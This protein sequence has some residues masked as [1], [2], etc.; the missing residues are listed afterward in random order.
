MRCLPRLIPQTLRRSPAVAE[1]R[2]LPASSLQG[3]V[4][5]QSWLRLP[6]PHNTA[7]VEGL[8]HL[9]SPLLIEFAS[10]KTASHVLDVALTSSTVEPR[11]RRR[12]IQCLIACGLHTLAAD[13]IGSRVCD[14]CW[15][16]ADTFLKGK[17]AAALVPYLR[18]LHGSEYGR[19]FARKLQLPVF[20][21][22]RDVWASKIAQ[23]EA[24]KKSRQQQAAAVTS[25]PKLGKAATLPAGAT[26]ADEIDA[27]FAA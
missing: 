18:E 24:A 4:L 22:S 10:D 17:M 5:L 25:K 16:A 2:T 3:A 26:E 21:T 23:Q 9:P 15:D 6:S 19:F 11:E 8:R 27:A 1:L 13:R 12:L 14:T 7:V 20:K